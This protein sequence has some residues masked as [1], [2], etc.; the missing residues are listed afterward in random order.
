M[1]NGKKK[2]NKGEREL[3]KWFEQWTGFEFSRIPASGG[4]R[5][6]GLTNATTGDIICTD[7][8]HGRRFLLSVES[9]TYKDIN[10]EHYILGNKKNRVKDFWE[11][12]KSDAIRGSKFPI[13][14]MRYNGMKKNTWFVIIPLNLYKSFK[15]NLDYPCFIVGKEGL[16]IMNS[17]DLLKVKYL[18]LHKT[19]KQWRKKE[20]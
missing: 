11:Q 4:L 8:I 18:E 10:F 7:N 3:C 1:S 16:V 5:W 12:A 19:L 9:K 6:K 2:G 13:L 14:F 15:I 20:K 17:E